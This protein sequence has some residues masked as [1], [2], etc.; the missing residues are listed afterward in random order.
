MF[1]ASCAPLAL[2]YLLFSAPQSTEETAYGREDEMFA[3]AFGFEWHLFN[4]KAQ[5]GVMPEQY[6]F[7]AKGSISGDFVVTVGRWQLIVSRLR[8]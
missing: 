1:Y 8:R 5:Y 2:A 4:Y 7:I 3:R 6:R